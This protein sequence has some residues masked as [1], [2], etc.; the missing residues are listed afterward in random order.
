MNAETIDT[1][2]S[3]INTIQSNISSLNVIFAKEQIENYAKE[4]VNDLEA[5]EESYTQYMDLIHHSFSSFKQ[6]IIDSSNFYAHQITE[7]S[8]RCNN[9]LDQLMK[10]IT[11]HISSNQLQSAKIQQVDKSCLKKVTFQY[12]NGRRHSIGSDLIKKYP[13]SM[14]YQLYVNQN[15]KKLQKSLFIDCDDKNHAAIVNYMNGKDIDSDEMDEKQRMELVQDLVY[16]QLPI[17]KDQ[18]RQLFMTKELQK[19]KAWENRLVTLNNVKYDS[20]NAYLKTNG[21]ID[22]YFNNVS[23]KDIHYMSEE[24][25]YYVNIDCPYGEF[26]DSYCSTH[27]MNYQWLSDLII[28]KGAN[29]LEMAD[30]FHLQFSSDQRQYIKFFLSPYFPDSK[31]VTTIQYEQL[32]HEWFGDRQWTLLYRYIYYPMILRYRA[33][34]HK[35]KATSFHKYCDDKGPTIVFIKSID[36]SIFGGYTT[37]SWKYTKATKGFEKIG[38]ISI[39]F[40]SNDCRRQDQRS[41]SIYILLEESL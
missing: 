27:Q 14:Y 38:C 4:C 20:L 32:F 9:N 5:C 3:I 39:F 22:E 11:S 21:Y 13:G 30:F 34:E 1:I 33:S 40:I 25:A 12:K 37:Q 17:K 10:S 26:F 36:G 41:S 6:E 8:T 31:I 19:L 29:L 23:L 7:L 28:Q 18:L 2:N 24:D 15:L 35:F 16:L